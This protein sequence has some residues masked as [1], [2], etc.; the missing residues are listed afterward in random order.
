VLAKYKYQLLLLLVVILCYCPLTFFQSTLLNDDI[1]VAL[2]TKYFAGECLQNGMLPLWNPYQ[3]WG[4][5]AHTDLQYTN[6]NCEVLITGILFG[7]TYITMHLQFILYLFLAALGAFLLFRYLSNHA[8]NSFYIACVYVLSGIVTA[9]IQSLVTIL[10]IVWLPYVILY[11]LIWLKET[12]AKNTILLCVFSYLLLTLGYQA[13][14]FMLLPPFVLLLLY[15]LYSNYKHKDFNS[16]KRKLISGGGAIVLMAV[17]LSPV[18]VT[19]LQSKPFVARLNG[20]SVNDVMSNPF[21]PMG[22]LSFIDPLLT[23][24]HDAWFNADLTMRN[25]FIGTLPLL[26]LLI[27]VVKKHKDSLDLILLGFAVFY[28]LGS[29]GDVI[30]VRKLMYHVLPGFNLFRFPSLLRVVTILL[31]LCYWA[32]NFNESVKMIYD[33]KRLRT[34][35]LSL[36]AFVCM[37][38]MI[39]CFYKLPAFTFFTITGESFNQ[40][41]THTNPLELCFYIS[42]FQCI[43]TVTALLMLHRPQSINEFKQKLA[44]FTLTELTVVVLVYGQFTAFTD[45]KPSTFQD[46]FPKL[47]KGFPFPTTDPLYISSSKFNTLEGFWK[48]TGAFKKQLITDDAWTSF[49]FINYD[50]LNLYTPDLKD[51]LLSYP[52]IYFSKPAHETVIKLPVDTSLTFIRNTFHPKNAQGNFTYTAYSP[53]KITLIADNNTNLIL[54]L[55]QSYFTGWSVKID[56]TEKPLVWNAGLLMSVELP[57]GL[58]T[59]EFNYQNKIFVYCLVASYSLLFLLIVILISL[60][61]YS[62]SRKWLFLLVF[63]MFTALMVG[64]FFSRQN[65]PYDTQ[66]NFSFNDPGKLKTFDFNSNAGIYSAWKQ[67]QLSGSKNTIY[68]WQN[69]LNA[70][71]LLYYLGLNPDSL[72]STTAPLNGTINYRPYSYNSQSLL[73]VNF[74]S[75]YTDKSFIDTTG[76]NAYAL[77]LN[78]LNPYT[79]LMKISAA[80]VSGHR[81]FGTVKLKRTAFSNATIVCHVKHS[82]GAEESFYFPLNKYV[83]DHS[84]WQTLPYYFNV[85]HHITPTDQVNMFL[86]NPS[87]HAVFIK[88]V[89]AVYFK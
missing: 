59:V 58:H 6:W 49:Y 46:N 66:N 10:G 29:F 41:I 82:N 3:I 77:Q 76:H 25:V 14:T 55:Q 5:P 63:I 51:S 53:N 16:I 79:K 47:Q 75:T 50:R 64:L 71:E 18:L 81:V 19:Q 9:H 44:V 35:S 61:S 60:G 23:I 17:L 57:A 2:S 21:S 65:T 78:D 89:E 24:G 31:L 40:R 86:M 13:F 70:P 54:N 62:K 87:A 36:L 1:D 28:L 27:A 8:R 56:G 11:F 30:P 26:L 85:K 15:E 80:E 69:Y 4:F 73:A 33:N 74:D 12:T 32:K 7:Y 20:M 22:M 84:D 43:I 52:F 88:N 68:S 37:A 34:V 72:E 67:V 42:V 45:L 83:L 48:N 38:I 39:Y